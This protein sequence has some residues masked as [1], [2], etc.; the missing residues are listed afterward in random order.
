MMDI[1]AS[2]SPQRDLTL[3]RDLLA[4]SGL[5]D[6]GAYVSQAGEEARPDPIG[7]YLRKGWHLGLEP[8][9]SFPGALLLPYFA[10]LG[11]DEPPA[12]TWLTLRSAGWPLPE[13]WEEV[14]SSAEGIRDTGLFDQAFYMGQIGI[15]GIG[16][17]P[18]IHYL[19]VG[20]RMGIAPSAEFDPDYY[21]ERYPEV[22]AQVGN[23]LRHY[24]DNGYAEGRTGRPARVWASG[25]AVIEPNRENV[26][27]VVHDTSRTGAPILGWNIA[28]HLASRYNV[29]TVRVG[30]GELTRQFEA[31]SV[32]VHGPFCGSRHHE[33]DVEYSLRPLLDA[34]KYRYVI[35][36]SIESRLVVE[37]CMRRFIPTVLL[38]HEFA[39]SVIPASSLC[40]ALDWSTE[41]V[42]AAPIVARS[43][44]EVHPILRSRAIHVI[45]QGKVVLP[46]SE[47]D[48]S[49][50]NA[51]S[52]IVA[53]LT[54]KRDVDG[55]FIVVGV[56]TVHL[57]K[58]VDLFL[59][60]AAAVIRSRPSRA[61][62][63]VWVGHGY[64]PREDFNYS[65]YLYEQLNRSGL[66]DHVTFLDVVPD[67]GPIYRLAD[68]F[69]LS[70]RLDPL[71]NVAI[72]SA[73]RGIPVICFKEASGMADLMLSHPDTACT[74]VE[75]LDAEA[76]GKVILE[77]AEDEAL[78]KR[79]SEAIR[80]LAHL[81][82]DMN[83]YFAQLDALGTAASARM[84]QRT[85]DAET[86]R[87]DPAFDQDMFLGPGHPI[88]TRE[89]TIARYLA[90]AAAR[91]W[92]TPPAQAHQLRRPAPGFNPRIYAAAH[93]AS[94]A[95]VTDPLADFVRRGRPVGSWQATVLRPDD[96]AAQAIPLG[97]L[98]VALHAHMFYPD[99]CGDFLAHLGANQTRCDLLVSTDDASKA[100][101][102]QRVLSSYT[103]GVVDIR[104]VPNRG[105]DIGPLLTEFVDDLNDYDLV[106]HVH[107]KRCLWSGQKMLGDGWRE[108]L[109]QN[110]LGG[111]YPMMD[112]IVAAFEQQ[113]RLGL[114]FPSDSHLIGW[115]ANRVNAG[116]IAARMGWNGT[117]PDYF[118]FP[119]GTMF[120]TRPESLRPLLN[121][122][123]TWT[124]YPEEP[125]AYDG[126]LLH[127]LER[128][129]TIA[130]QL[131]GFTHA[132]THVYGVSW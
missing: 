73:V 10:A 123:L 54:S 4:G 38:M 43:A 31:L 44:Q 64:R 57:R 103:G 42:F 13:R 50:D 58:G 76:A 19:I 60:A 56:G 122:G 11:V 131:A 29:F 12:I 1:A 83:T 115:D 85:A 25:R 3:E 92:D 119:L 102:I 96:P 61:I 78:R 97:R 72:D 112:R 130:S 20:E 45:P 121:L 106:G 70:S 30:D 99:L 125:V 48:R 40:A 22:A 116:K 80:E 87:R 98:R 105:R 32:E 104:V 71:P 6:E 2:S 95:G 51:T 110:L 52:S 118:D 34:R 109:W 39:S 100:E 120:W 77:L 46:T 36:N 91:G 65:V 67:L 9:L 53:Q 75:H 89:V 21:R 82:F 37:P 117:L 127:A 84:K 14:Q 93:A 68:A 15:G 17:D 18:A 126:T 27:L 47:A 63:F 90:L 124:E 74:V 28:L 5:F 128:L 86:L 88:E 16:L 132:V 114:V 62:H 7:H 8:S 66:S 129:P 59:A 94:L 111:L 55:T 41:I 113:D 33:V 23:C 35:V 107:S 26:I 69:F 101:Q 79:T 108:F 49:Q 81:N 24:A